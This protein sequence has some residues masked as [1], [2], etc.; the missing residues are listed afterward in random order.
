[1]F[2]V[3]AKQNNKSLAH[4]LGLPCVCVLAWWRPELGDRWLC[5]SSYFRASHW[6]TRPDILPHILY[7][8]TCPTQTIY[9]LGYLIG[10]FVQGYMCCQVWFKY[11][12]CTV[13]SH[14]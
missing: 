5:R 9:R 11:T 10:P 4:F 7:N 12:E 8:A 14:F 6:A 13:N 3:I 2:I 1:L